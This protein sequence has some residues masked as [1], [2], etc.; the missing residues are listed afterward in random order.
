MSAIA[1]IDAAAS[2]PVT[3]IVYVQE[4][5]SGGGGS[6]GG[7]DNV[8]A[9]DDGW[10]SNEGWDTFPSYGAGDVFVPEPTLAIVGDRAGGE[11]IGGIDQAVARFGSTP[12]ST[13][14]RVVNVTVNQN[15][16]IANVG[17]SKEEL[18]STLQEQSDWLKTEICNQVGYTM[19]RAEDI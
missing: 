14:L 9:I 6:S 10:W 17:T 18:Q 13:S 16:D 4:V 12:G 11:W 2:A 1:A 8:N 3:K 19:N 5:S 7:Y 15:V